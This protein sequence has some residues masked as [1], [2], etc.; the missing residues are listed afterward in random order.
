[1]GQFW[2][3]IFETFSFM[4]NKTTDP[5]PQLAIFG[6]ARRDLAQTHALAFS[7]EPDVIL[8]DWKFNLELQRN[9]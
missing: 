2:D 4:C 5:E 1:M 3:M 7:S 9:L 6:V 8:Y